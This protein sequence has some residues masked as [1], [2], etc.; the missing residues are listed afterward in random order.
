MHH[1]PEAAFRE[2]SLFGMRDC[3]EGLRREFR[4][5]V[6]EHF[7]EFPIREQETT[8]QIAISNSGVALIN[9][10]TQP[11]LRLAQGLL[12]SFLFNAER[13]LARNR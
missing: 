3:E 1:F 9:N 10:C 8:G 5:C 13:K 12:D 2:I 6:P 7:A 11:F 4:L